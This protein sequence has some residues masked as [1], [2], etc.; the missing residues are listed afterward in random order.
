MTVFAD[1]DSVDPGP[2]RFS[3][4]SFEY[5][6]RSARPSSAAIRELIESWFA[7]YPEPHQRHM[8]QR[9]RHRDDRH[10]LSAFFEL[11]LHALFR[12]L[13]FDVDVH[14]A[15]PGSNRVPD[16]RLTDAKGRVCYLEATSAFDES[17]A[18]RAGRQRAAEALDILNTVS[19]PDFFLGV[20][21]DSLPRH[22]IPARKFRA[23]VERFLASL[24]Y[25]AARRATVRDGTRLPRFRFEHEGWT[26]EIVAIPKSDSNRSSGDVR[27]LGMAIPPVEWGRPDA[28][29]RHAIVGKAS[30]YG[31]LGAPFLIAVNAHGMSVDS[32]TVMEALFGGETYT[33]TLDGHAEIGEPRFGRVRDGVWI[34]HSGA[35][36]TRVSAVLVAPAI[37]P[38]S[39]MAGTPAVYMNPDARDPL[40]L[41]VSALNRFVPGEGRMHFHPGARPGEL[42]GLPDGWPGD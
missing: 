20:D 22:P 33:I 13:A 24:D 2:A 8:R 25:R 5:L 35:R 41:D 40:T 21:Y 26:A 9:L 39:I 30:R 28:A 3:E 34:S 11:Y 29:I 31:T 19:S 14:P 4:P 27:S 6:C 7:L 32:E 12:G 15:I 18:T 23:D 42:L 36:Y 17:P 16:F 38:W 10:F 1:C 37:T